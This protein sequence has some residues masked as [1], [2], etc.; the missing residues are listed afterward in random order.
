M[1]DQPD[2]TPA[3]PGHG[4]TPDPVR[5]DRMSETISFAEY[6]KVVA[7]ATQ[8][9]HR[10]RDLE[11][12]LKTAVAERDAAV[13]ARGDLETQLA[14]LQEEHEQLALEADE[15]LTAVETERDDWKG[16]YEAAPSEHLAELN[17]LKDQ[18]RQDK[19]KSAFRKLALDQLNPD[20][21]DDAWDL[22]GYKAEGDEPDEAAISQ[23]LKGLVESRRYLAKPV[24]NESDDSK[25]AP[26][27]ATPKTAVA[28][29][30]G[31]GLER[32]GQPP[33]AE[34]AVPAGT[35]AKVSPRDANP[36]RIA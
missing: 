15:A 10:I 7:Q 23:A 17:T 27:G 24:A 34:D 30:R 32:G 5:K 21:I 22:S 26:G 28:P 11:A 13:A 4:A 20:A 31:P 25:S 9:K 12:E 14:T 29:R 18:I 8:R 33:R 36:Y 6:Q 1:P 3:D 2:I 19:H 35:Q 16:K